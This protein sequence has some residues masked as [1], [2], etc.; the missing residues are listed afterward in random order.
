MAS[1]SEF[2]HSIAML[3]YQRVIGYDGKP[4]K[5]WLLKNVSGLESSQSSCSL[6]GLPLGI[7]K[8]PATRARWSPG[9]PVMTGMWAHGDGQ[10]MG[11]WSEHLGIDMISPMEMI[12]LWL[13]WIWATDWDLSIPRLGFDHQMES[14]GV[15]T[16]IIRNNLR[17]TG[18][19]SWEIM[20]SDLL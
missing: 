16:A 12:I 5:R 2:S 11:R 14:S 1:Y 19:L 6:S 15:A 9:N 20:W 17:L 7:V 18:R 10:S 4:K 8:V 13:E 3:V